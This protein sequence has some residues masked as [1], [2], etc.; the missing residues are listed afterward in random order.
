M[1]EI[2]S[3]EAFIEEKESENSLRP[4]D[5]SE[6]IGQNKLVENLKIFIEAAKKRNE[7]L[8]HILFSGP[9]G[10]GKTTLAGIIKREM[11]SNLLSTSGPILERPGDLASILTALKEFDCLFI[12][13]IHRINK[14]VSELL[15]SAMEDFRIDIL[16]G[17]GA[18]ARSIKLPLPRFT[19][20]G[21]TTRQGL[22]AS[23]LRNRFG[24]SQV[25]SFYSEDE[26]FSIILRSS[27]ILNIETEED[28]ACIIAKRSRGTPRIANRLLRRIR[29]YAQVKGKG[30]ITEDIASEGLM[31]LE[32]DRF[33][34][35][36]MDRRILD[37]LINKFQGRAIG[38]KTLSASLEEDERTISEVYEPYLLKIGFIERTPKGRKATE[39]AINYLSFKK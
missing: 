37:I 26:L 32:V 27:K 34:L 38:I 39:S 29:D 9:P 33:G 14:A 30:K 10:L 12:D 28:A 22:L 4:K 16:L 15:Y 6:F 5:F 36:S 18:S 19:L 8:D 31:R 17:K 21:A 35:D 1:K 7:Q 25:V 2:T 13:E 3:P 20:I 23:P 11:G 24:I